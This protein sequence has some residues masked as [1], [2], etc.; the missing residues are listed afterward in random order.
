M[1]K[2]LSQIQDRKVKATNVQF[3][4]E[5][6][7]Y[8]EIARNIIKNNPF[9]RNK[10]Q[11]KG[12][13]YSLLK[14]DIV[15]G[16]VIPPIV[17]AST[18]SSSHSDVVNDEITDKDLSLILGGYSDLKILDGL[19]RTLT[20][21]EA[22]DANKDY[23]DGLD[24]PYLIRVEI[25]LAID[26]AG[27]LYRMLTLNTGQ[28]PMTLRHQLEILYSKYLEDGIDGL[29]ILKDV[30]NKPVKSVYAYKFSD[31]IDGYTSYLEM[32]ELPIDR[33]D[34]L[35]A[36][37][38]AE[39]VV[40]ANDGKSDFKNFALAFNS[41]VLVFNDFFDGW[42][43]PEE[44]VPDDYQIDSNPYGDTL[45]SIFNKSQT[46]TGFGAAIAGL[47]RDEV[48]SG[49]SDVRKM[50]HLLS[51]DQDDLLYLNYCL[52]QIKADAKKI[53][54]AQRIFFKFFFRSIF[55]KNSSYYLNVRASLGRA[56]DRTMS[57][58]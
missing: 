47:V 45:Y 6:S 10:V 54:P 20:L 13:V 51:F 33:V 39:F 42:E 55:D 19:Q 30:D 24:D 40:K 21:I 36:V 58:L 50:A 28:T 49:I 16:C 57:E 34:I 25:Y 11:K 52:D 29:D 38:A 41:V 5:I 9:Q 37:K 56:Y 26:E 44:G 22:Y 14:G 1:N 8:V 46:L 4:I 15:A 18:L 43:Y 53:G 12:S 48:L 31:L 17:L 27:I 3:V 7:E 23:F 2:I 35:N 32:N